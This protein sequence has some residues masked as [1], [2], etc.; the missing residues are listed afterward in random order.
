MP[1]DKEQRDGRD[2]GKVAAKDA[3]RQIEDLKEDNARLRATVDGLTAEQR[4]DVHPNEVLGDR[5]C[6]ECFQADLNDSVMGHIKERDEAY[7]YLS[8]LFVSCA[9]QCEPL[10]TLPGLATQIDNYIAGC[11]Q[12]KASAESSLQQ[13]TQER[14][15]LQEFYNRCQELGAT[16]TDIVKHALEDQARLKEVGI[17]RYQLRQ[18]FS[19]AR[20]RIAKD[21][22][23]VD[24]LARLGEQRATASSNKAAPASHYGCSH[25]HQGFVHEPTTWSRGGIPA[26]SWY[27]CS[28]DCLN[29]WLRGDL[30]RPSKPIP[31]G[32]AAV[33]QRSGSPPAA[34]VV[35]RPATSQHEP[36]T[37]VEGSSSCSSCESLEARVSA[38]REYVQHRPGCGWQEDDTFDRNRCTCGLSAH[39]SEAVPRDVERCLKTG[40]PCGTDT[41][42]RGYSCDCTNCL[43]WEAHRPAKEAVPRE[44]GKG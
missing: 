16:D 26:T 27:F 9:P 38:L 41:V 28:V 33:H 13:I 6:Q 37:R 14:D 42:P 8:R 2:M 32:N 35:D 5:V 34:D 4:C 20:A 11:H 30:S 36:S 40:N 39:L 43:L 23:S 17:E 25:C 29:A 1:R 18:S 31:G 19:E 12:A 22:A 7:G 10:P 21:V 24:G 15:Q 3:A 44:E